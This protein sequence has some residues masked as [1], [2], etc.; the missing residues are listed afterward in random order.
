MVKVIGIGYGTKGQLMSLM[1]NLKLVNNHKVLNKIVELSQDLFNSNANLSE[2]FDNNNKCLPFLISLEHLDGDKGFKDNYGH[3]GFLFNT[4]TDLQTQK[5]IE[6]IQTEHFE[7]LKNNLIKSLIKNGKYQ[8]IFDNTYQEITDIN[9][10][11]N[12][13]TFNKGV[14]Y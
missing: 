8:T 2:A 4:Q 7:F 14:D 13:Y 5:I 1:L 6:A 12:V 9:N 11:K 3:L 10:F